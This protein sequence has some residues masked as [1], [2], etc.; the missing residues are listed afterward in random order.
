M[1]IET[2][3]KTQ[4][5]SE[6]LYSKYDN[7]K[8]IVTFFDKAIKIKSKLPDV[9]WFPL[10]STKSFHHLLKSHWMQNQTRS[11]FHQKTQSSNQ[12]KYYS[13]N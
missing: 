7:F 6:K 4:R 11:K 3:I 10:R 2:N 12:S 8:L 9:E 5:T 1:L 13:R